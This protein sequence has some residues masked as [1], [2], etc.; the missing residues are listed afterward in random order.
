M[1]EVFFCF[2]FGVGRGVDFDVDG[3]CF[4][5]FCWWVEFVVSVALE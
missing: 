1:F 4:E 5:F 3:L 2:G